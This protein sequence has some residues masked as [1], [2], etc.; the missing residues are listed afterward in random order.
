MF[1]FC[2][3][4]AMTDAGTEARI[5]LSLATTSSTAQVLHHIGTVPGQDR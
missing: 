5:Q 2:K 3:L 1:W 4:S